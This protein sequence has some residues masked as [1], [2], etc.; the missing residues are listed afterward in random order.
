MASES[1]VRSNVEYVIFDLDGILIQSHH[2]STILIPPQGLMI[3][4]EAVYTRVTSQTRLSPLLRT[5]IVGL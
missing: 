4:S 1:S 5:L 2:Q 3:D